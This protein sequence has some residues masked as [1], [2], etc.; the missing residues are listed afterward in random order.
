MAV[1]IG[2]NVAP[3]FPHLSDSRH[4]RRIEETRITGADRITGITEKCSIFQ[5]PLRVPREMILR[6]SA[7]TEDKTSAVID[8]YEKFTSPMIKMQAKPERQ[9][10]P[11]VT[12]G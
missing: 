6:T 3:Q 5:F 9:R 8:L 4:W 11:S 1:T 7:P 2:F 12:G 10:N